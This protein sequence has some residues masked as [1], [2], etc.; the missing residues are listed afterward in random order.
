VRGNHAFNFNSHVGLGLGRD[1]LWDCKLPALSCQWP[2]VVIQAR[3]HT[4]GLIAGRCFGFQE[5]QGNT[6][7]GPLAS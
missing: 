2:S 3:F 4:I 7:M 5:Q 1:K 6:G